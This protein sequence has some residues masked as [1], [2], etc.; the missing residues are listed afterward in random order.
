VHPEI[1]KWHSHLI[2]KASERSPAEAE[3]VKFMLR[4]LEDDVF[5]IDQTKRR[6]AKDVKAALLA[7]FKKYNSLG[8]AELAGPPE[9]PPPSPSNFWKSL[10]PLSR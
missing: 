5:E 9:K 7:T 1:H 8:E 2:E 6:A 4:H 3:A 10:V